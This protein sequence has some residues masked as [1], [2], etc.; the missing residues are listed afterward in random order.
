M[1]FDPVSIIS[2]VICLYSKC[3]CD[4]ALAISSVYIFIVDLDIRVLLIGMS[5]RHL[6]YQASKNISSKV[7]N[8]VRKN[9]ALVLHLLDRE[10][11]LE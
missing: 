5:A 4:H 8:L 1:G 9:Y 11:K 6:K 3:W 10:K 7:S 2:L